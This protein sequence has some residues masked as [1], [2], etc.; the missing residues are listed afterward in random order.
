MENFDRLVD[1]FEAS[2]D[3][4][5]N[6]RRKIQKNRVDYPF[7]ESEMSRLYRYAKRIAPLFYD[8][9][10]N[11]FNNLY[12]TFVDDVLYTET[13]VSPFAFIV[14]ST[15]QFTYSPNERVMPKTN[16]DERILDY[17]IFTAWQRYANKYVYGKTKSLEYEPFEA[18]CTEFADVVAKIC[19]DNGIECYIIRLN[20]GFIDTARLYDKHKIHDFCIIKLN[21]GYYL[22]DPSYRQFFML[23]ASSLDRVGVPFLGGCFPGV[24][25]KLSEERQ[26]VATNL[27]ERGYLKFTPEN[28]KPYFDG[29]AL[30]F[31]NGLYY[32][33]TQDY[34]YTT[35]Y[36]ADDYV[37]FLKGEDSQVNHEGE[38]VLKRQKT[39][40]KKM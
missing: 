39:L 37:S 24:F 1:L 38:E 27:I 22:I 25:M 18:K 34:S 29:F 40:Y 21:D 11:R 12:K 13:W 8:E 3:R 30:S 19:E 36:T 16:Y 14:P 23:R 15:P 4:V 9:E 5:Q 31:R 6:T 26:A 35:S 33:I 7:I 28:I 17:I 2:T 32:D 20:P 10:Q